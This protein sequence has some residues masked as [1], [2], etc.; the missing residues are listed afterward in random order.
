MTVPSHNSRERKTSTLVFERI[1]VALR[2]DA[3]DR[4]LLDFSGVLLSNGG[5]TRRFVHVAPS[6]PEDGALPE[7]YIQRHGGREDEILRAT[8]EEKADLLVVGSRFASRRRKL[9]RRLAMKAPCSVLVVP[10]NYPARIRGILA[11]VDFSPLSAD[12]LHLAARLARQLGLASVTALHAYFEPATVSY[13]EHEKV[14]RDR[15]TGGFHSFL[16]PLDLE[17]TKIDQVLEESSS[18]V[19]AVEA[20][21]AGREIDLVVMGTRGR[22]LSSSILLGSETE[23]MIQETNVPL[24]AVKHFGSTLPLLEALLASQVQE[25]RFG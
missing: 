20:V 24:L 7:D 5:V 13:E 10:Q 1:L 17:G 3:T 25:P 9:I 2:G 18:V 23:H 22:S 6:T 4:T 11:A 16:N 14:A 15:E 21:L 19:H 12:A 8:V